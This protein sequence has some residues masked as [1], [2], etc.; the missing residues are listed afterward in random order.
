MSQERVLS[1][2][3]AFGVSETDVEV[4]IF[5]A[6]KGP[7]IGRELSKA[8]NKNK[9]QV[10]RSLKELHRKNLVIA[11]M[12]NSPRFQAVPFE[13]VLDLFIKTRMEEAKYFQKDKEGLI[14][15]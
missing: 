3:R 14:F 13:R 9:Q 1:I 11:T 7:Q 4:Y 5:L 15:P 10:V 2:I 8:L 12:E 6:K